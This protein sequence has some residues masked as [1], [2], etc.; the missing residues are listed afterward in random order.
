MSQIW[1]LV[2]HNLKKEKGQY[3]SFGLILCITALIINMAMVL[4]RQMDHAYDEKAE[5]LEAADI[6][7]LAP[8]HTS[9]LQ[10]IEELDAVSQV[11]QREALMAG[12]VVKDFRGTDFDMNLIYYNMDETHVM[13]QLETMEEG[14][15]SDTKPADNTASNQLEIYLPLYIS[16]FGEYQVGEKIEMEVGEEVSRFSIKGTVQEMQF[17]NYGG[18][19]MGVYLPEASYEKFA[20]EKELYEITAYSIQLKD[21]ATEEAVMEELRQVM[22]EEQNTPLYLKGAAENKQTRTM[23]C[24]LIM[25]ILLA[26]AVIVLLVSLFLCKFR[27][28]NKIEGEMTNLGV[29]KALGYTSSQIIQ[30]MMIPYIAT[31]ILASLIG[32][33]SSYFVLPGISEM[34]ALQSGLKFAAAFDF[35]CL[36]LVVVVLFLFISIFTYISAGKIRKLQPIL[37]IRGMQDGAKGG[38]GYY[39]LL[40]LVM[41]VMTILISFAGILS[42]NVVIKPE[43]FMRTLSEETPSVILQVDAT[44][45]AYIKE[46]LQQHEQVEQVL[47]YG[48]TTVEVEGNTLTAFVCEDFGKVK[49]DLCYEGRNPQQKDEIALGSSLA[50]QENLSIGDKVSVTLENTTKTYTIVGLVQSVNYQGQICELTEEAMEILQNQPQSTSFYIYLK[51]G[52]DAEKFVEEVKKAYEQ[53][54]YQE[55]NYEKMTQTS[56]EMYT[57]VVK[58]VIAAISII[59]V[60]IILL[61]LFI[62]MK[63]YLVQNRQELGIYKALGYSNK[64]LMLKLATNFLP[65]SFVAVMLSALL[66]KGYMPKILETTFQMVG[67]MKNH[68]QVPLE[69]LLI[70]GGGLCLV[71][72]IISICLTMPIK[73][74]SA[75]SLIRE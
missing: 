22:Q 20:K 1:K 42:Y 31:G 44:Q 39:V 15:I 57:G 9:L 41:F 46:E 24:T 27:I 53:E 55:I 19:M 61:I 62:I 52:A 33:G 18:G 64:Q 8:E 36:L 58:L 30:S 63:S 37:A 34:L 43:N 69:V 40:F 11:E 59:T 45:K 35:G 67:A 28:Q 75:Y 21:Y 25:V 6:T 16:E 68:C 17:G 3:V 26:F 5:Q 47:L 29:L 60:F 50:E 4:V 73:R 51:E 74:I 70:F 14:T 2:V 48:S 32:I 66:G 72:F 56:Q 12:T 71:T 38:K 65:V 23:V 7:L 10:K 13:N 49:N 54:I